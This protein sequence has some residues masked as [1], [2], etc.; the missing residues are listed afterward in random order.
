MPCAVPCARASTKHLRR[1]CSHT[2]DLLRVARRLIAVEAREFIQ[3]AAHAD[4]VRSLMVVLPRHAAP[5][6]GACK[7]RPLT[8]AQR[9][10]RAPHARAE[11]ARARAACGVRQA[12]REWRAKAEALSAELA[13]EHERLDALRRERTAGCGV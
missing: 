9:R 4:R 3:H 1:A 6:P 13:R 8:R 7:G 12:Q 2:D 10:T 5:A 11:A